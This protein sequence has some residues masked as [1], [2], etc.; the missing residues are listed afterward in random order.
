MDQL[1]LE[2]RLELARIFGATTLRGHEDARII[3]V[4]LVFAT[5]RTHV[6]ATLDDGAR[7]VVFSYFA[8]ELTFTARQFVGM[9]LEEAHNAFYE[10]DVNYMQEPT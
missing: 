5:Y 10:A 8:D 9:T 1:T 6:I 2:E 7:G 3:D 4:E